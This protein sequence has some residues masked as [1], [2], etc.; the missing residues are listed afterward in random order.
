MLQILSTKMLLLISGEIGTASDVM[1]VNP[2]KAVQLTGN[3]STT[4][5]VNCGISCVTPAILIDLVTTCRELQA[6]SY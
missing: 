1:S 3:L 4:Y 5:F 2:C 6:G